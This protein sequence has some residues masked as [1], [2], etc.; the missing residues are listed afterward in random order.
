MIRIM[1]KAFVRDPDQP[2][3][4]HCPRCGAIGATVAAATI[5]AHLREGLQSPL[6][7]SACFCG[8]ASCEVAYFDTNGQV[9]PTAR[10][11]AAVYP[12]HPEAP[13]CACFGLKAEDVAADA[14]ADNA[15][16]VRMLIERSKK[17]GERCATLAANGRSCVDEVQRVYLK[18][19]KR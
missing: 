4:A 15:A 19:W 12:K 5:A 18:H 8:N 6:G 2:D 9:I 1:N 16:G 17:Q 13:I 7:S 10:L 3:D 14:R 11:R